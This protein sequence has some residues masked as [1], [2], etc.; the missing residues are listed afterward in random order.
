MEFICKASKIESR[1]GIV[2]SKDEKIELTKEQIR[3]SP[4]LTAAVQNKS[5]VLID[6]AANLIQ[7]E[8]VVEKKGPAASADSR[9]HG[10]PQ[11][12]AKDKD[13]K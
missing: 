5:L 6:M 11:G 12:K 8:T 4:A 2:V 10:K 7:D 9:G 13:E 3:E 1:N